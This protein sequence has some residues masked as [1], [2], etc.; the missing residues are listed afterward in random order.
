LPSIVRTRIG[1]KKPVL[2]GGGTLARRGVRDRSGFI[3]RA[4]YNPPA[5]HAVCSF[6]FMFLRIRQVLSVET[7]TLKFDSSGRLPWVKCLETSLIGAFI[8]LKPQ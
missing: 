8:Y 6:S 1:D 5:G 2:D 7:G 4:G 3:T